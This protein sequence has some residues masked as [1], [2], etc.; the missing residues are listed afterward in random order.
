MKTLRLQFPFI[1]SI[2]LLITTHAGV[3]AQL[4]ITISTTSPNAD[5]SPNTFIGTGSQIASSLLASDTP[6]FLWGVV[7]SADVNAVCTQIVNTG[8]LSF[9]AT[10]NAAGGTQP[11]T[12]QVTAIG[13]CLAA[14]D[15]SGTEA[16]LLD[17]TGRQ[18][19][20]VCPNNA[21]SSGCGVYLTGDDVSTLYTQ[22][23]RRRLLS[24]RRLLDDCQDGAAKGAVSGAFTGLVDSAETCEEFVLFAPFCVIGVVGVNAGLGAAEGCAEASVCF[25]GD[26]TVTLAS[27]EIKPMTA[28]ALGDKVAVQTNND[29]ELL[30]EDVYAF[31]HKDSSA[32][33]AFVQLTL[34]PVGTNMSDNSVEI[35][36]LE[37]SASHFAP[38]VQ[39]DDAKKML[40]K[41]GGA[42]TVGDFMLAEGAPMYVVTS[43][44]RVEKAGLYN[45]FTLSGTIV[46]NGVVASTHSDWFLDASFDFL[47]LTHWLPATYQMVLFPVRFLYQ[48][49]GKELYISLYD[50]LDALVDIAALGTTYGGSILA[51]MGTS[52]A[53]VVALLLSNILKVPS[54]TRGSKY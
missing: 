7:S 33:A 13:G 3:Q 51:V 4:T 31:G 5:G 24:A 14:S 34:K 32:V 18:S 54:S 46:V 27:G 11:L 21:G 26:A 37:L 17:N 9:D 40:Y 30:Y 1:F 45:P 47:G 35:K 2:L 19:A 48:V 10:L 23:A 50:Q 43:I 39:P 38:L 53:I 41:R 16:V 15:G 49:L 42:I 36:V 22:G 8:S 28:L 25:P 52:S 44:S 29:D 12:M 20:V 6:A